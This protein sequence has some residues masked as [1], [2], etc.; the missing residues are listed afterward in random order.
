[1]SGLDPNTPPVGRQPF[2]APVKPSGRFLWYGGISG[3]EGNPRSETAMPDTYRV[4]GERFTREQ[5]EALKERGLRP[6][7]VETMTVKR[8]A[9]DREIYCGVGRLPPVFA[10]ECPVVKREADKV[11]VISPSGQ[12]AWVRPDGWVKAPRTRPIQGYM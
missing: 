5:A 9:T 3:S 4:G 11:R 12:L 10:M 2:A 8:Q 6:E 1:V 7:A